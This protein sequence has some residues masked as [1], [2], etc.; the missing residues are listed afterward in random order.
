MLELVFRV[1]GAEMEVQKKFLCDL[2]RFSPPK[3][4]SW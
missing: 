4:K 3:M 2:K 1:V